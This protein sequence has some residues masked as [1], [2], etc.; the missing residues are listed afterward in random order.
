MD[1]HTVINSQVNST[2]EKAWNELWRFTYETKDFIPTLQDL[3]IDKKTDNHVSRTMNIGP[4]KVKEDIESQKD[5]G[6]IKIEQH[7]NSD[8]KGT[9]LLKLY[10]NNE[11]KLMLEFVSGASNPEGGEFPPKPLFEKI[12]EGIKEKIEKMN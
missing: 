11:K 7:Q 5:K 10:E 1:Y 8:I 4:F 3:T 9:I 2:Y 12:L 6:C